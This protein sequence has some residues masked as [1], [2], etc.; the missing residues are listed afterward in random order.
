[1][2]TILFETEGQENLSAT[3]RAVV[4]AAATLGVAKV[5]VFTSC[6]DGALALR[7]KLSGD[8]E[9]IAVTFPWQMTAKPENDVIYIGMP[10]PQRR[11][12]LAAAGVNIVQG[13][14]PLHALGVDQADGRAVGAAYDAFGGSM[15][16]CMQAVV[17]ACDAGQLDAGERCIA[18]TSDT[19]VVARAGHSFNF[20][21][22][23]SN[24]A[25]EQFICKPQYYQITRGPWE[26]D[27]AKHFGG[28]TIEGS[29]GTSTEDVPVTTPELPPS[30]DR[31]AR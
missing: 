8:I 30:N 25:I 28:V 16:L 2:K 31:D 9:I 29:A 3:M 20:L 7:K 22:R 10:S 23:T 12:E 19:A 24:F 14:M 13:V 18:M 21:K 6:G 4:R 17:M 26:L 1:M 27:I 11:A 15:K 5:L